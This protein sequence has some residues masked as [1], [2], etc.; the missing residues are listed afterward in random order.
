MARQGP[1]P[2]GD[3]VRGATDPAR[4]RAEH[5]QATAE[6]TA[7]ILLV[8]VVLLAVAA[9]GL[10]QQIGSGIRAALCTV[11]PVCDGGTGG[12]T[13]TV[14]AAGGPGVGAAGAD[15]GGAAD[16]TVPDDGYDVVW[17]P[18]GADAGRRGAGG[19]FLDGLV[20]GNFDDS[21]P[22][23]GGE[24][25]SRAGG[26]LLSSVLIYGDVRDGGAALGDL[27]S[28]GGRDGWGDLLWSGVGLVPLGGDALKALKAGDKAVDGTRAASTA[29]RLGDDAAAAATRSMDDIAAGGAR[30]SQQRLEHIVL[31]HWP[32]SGAANAGKFADGTTARSLRDMIDDTVVPGAG[33]ANTRG[34]PGYIFERDLG[35]TIGVNIDG[36]PTSR[37]RV[38][39]DPGGNVV[40]AFPY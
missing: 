2:G 32:T 40:T 23:T 27:W 29:A 21:E 4:S 1:S 36:V 19:S 25:W 10:S 9:S 28:S 5:G 13:V 30:L 39:V 24:A 15:D 38:V 6:Y 8:G 33:R 31:R 7:L 14:D 35:S 17:P 3:P 26:E 18:P 37:L 11:T 34:R 12:V 16:A 20:K 22:A